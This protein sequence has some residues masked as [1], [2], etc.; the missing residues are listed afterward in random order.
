MWGWCSVFVGGGAP[1]S[2]VSSGRHLFLYFEA[3]TYLGQPCRDEHGNH[4]IHAE[5]HLWLYQLV[6]ADFWG[7]QKSYFQAPNFKFSLYSKTGPN[8]LLLPYWT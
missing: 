3:S 5:T 8:N 6:L 7:T 2:L 4:N 1:F